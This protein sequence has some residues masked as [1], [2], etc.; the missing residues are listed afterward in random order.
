M[1]K[2]ALVEL[3]ERYVRAAIA[4]RAEV[5]DSTLDPLR[6]G[7]I[8]Q[9]ALAAEDRRTK[10]AFYTPPALVNHLLDESLE[11]LPHAQ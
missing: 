5:P 6:V 7:E 1:R 11:P 9:G 10:G 2:D 8:Y 4:G 3:E